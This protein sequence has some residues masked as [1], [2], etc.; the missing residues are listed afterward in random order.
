MDFIQGCSKIFGVS[1]HYHINDCKLTELASELGEKL[2]LLQVPTFNLSPTAMTA[3][4]QKN[5]PKT[6]SYLNGF[7]VCTLSSVW[8]IRKKKGGAGIKKNYI[9]PHNLLILE[10][11]KRLSWQIPNPSTKQWWSFNVKNIMAVLNFSLCWHIMHE[12]YS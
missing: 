7:T 1:A 2:F 12:R 8:K 9:F 10:Y 3:P 11:S 6:F 4:S 5:P